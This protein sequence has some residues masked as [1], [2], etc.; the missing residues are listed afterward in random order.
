MVMTSRLDYNVIVFPGLILVLA[1][2]QYCSLY[3]VASGPGYTLCQPPRLCRL[4]MME[5]WSFQTCI[6]FTSALLV[7]SLCGVLM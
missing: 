2:H 3:L 4:L 7:T 1:I 5:N 6:G